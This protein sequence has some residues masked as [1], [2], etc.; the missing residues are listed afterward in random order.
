MVTKL[1]RIVDST[2]V[3]IISLLWLLSLIMIKIEPVLFPVVKDF[4]LTSTERADQT[5]TIYGNFYKDRDCEFI[6]TGAK[7]YVQNAKPTHVAIKFKDNKLDSTSERNVGFQEFGPWVLTL[8]ENNK[9]GVV[10]L[11]HTHQCH[12]GWAVRTKAGAL[13]VKGMDQ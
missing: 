11:T 7:L 13:S 3:Y 12:I 1:I 10:Q 5:I 8:P 9:R 6:G 4:N 2:L